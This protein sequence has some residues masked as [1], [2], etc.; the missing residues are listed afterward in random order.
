MAFM[1][2]E[3]VCKLNKGVSA[4]NEGFSLLEVILSVAILAIVT[5]PL[6]SFFTDSMRRSAMTAR[7][8]NATLT[9][10]EITEDLK[11]SPNLIQKNTA[12]DGSVSYGVPY[13]TDTLGYTVKEGG[14]FQTEDGTGELVLTKSLEQFDVKL[15]LSTQVSANETSRAMIYGVDDTTDVML[16]EQDQLTE[17]LVYFTAAAA[18]AGSAPSQEALKASLDRTL[19]ICVDYDGSAYSVRAYYDY[20]CTDPGLIGSADPHYISTDLANRKLSSLKN[21]YVLYDCMD[22]GAQDTVCFDLNGLPVTLSALDC[23]ILCQKFP[24]DHDG[25]LFTPYTLTVKGAEDSVLRLHANIR[26]GDQV[27]KEDGNPFPLFPV[28]Q[29]GT[30]VRMISVVVEVYEKDHME[31]EEPLAVIRTT[32]GE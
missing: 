5:V 19:H 29:S 3:R 10:Q 20:E 1:A 32:K 26:S 25:G 12:P 17:A 28:A 16:M 2:Q 31:T 27:V 8:Q 18:A 21:L 30:P 14:R 15:T 22:V 11:S 9:A 4:G 6:L 13:L 7:H 24:P 23:F